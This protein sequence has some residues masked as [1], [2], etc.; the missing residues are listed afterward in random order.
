MNVGYGTCTT[1]AQH[2]TRV[3]IW[4]DRGYSAARSLF[5]GT[6]PSLTE[7]YLER[8][9]GFEPPTPTFRKVL[10][11][12]TGAIRSHPTPPHPCWISVHFLA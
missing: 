4:V 3:G 1:L 6:R 7:F 2:L 11:C 9:R 8:A 12:L 10:L 5:V